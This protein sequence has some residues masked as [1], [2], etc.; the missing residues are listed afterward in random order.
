MRAIQVA[1]IGQAVV[2]IAFYAA[3]VSR[4]AHAASRDRTRQ[5]EERTREMR[6]QAAR[7]IAAR[8]LAEQASRAKSQFLATMSHELRTPLNAVIG[9]AEILQHEI[10]G[11][12]GHPRYMEDVKIIV[13]SGHSLLDLVNDILDISRIASDRFDVTIEPLCPAEILR[14]IAVSFRPKLSERRQSLTLEQ[15]DEGPPVQADRRRL[16]QCLRNLINNASRY[17]GKGA[18][19]ELRCAL[20]G[21]RL[22]IEILDD[23]PGIPEQELGNIK[24]PFYRRSDAHTT[25]KDGLGLGLFIVSHLMSAMGGALT[26]ENR[27]EGGLCARLSLPVTRGHGESDQPASEP[28]REPIVEKPAAA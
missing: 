2:M 7:A 8:E 21:E 24:T 5:L 12:L 15:P 28:T 17:A 14:E 1:L 6:D 19:I 27:P 18:A 11:P 23:G 3:R 16:K 22:T 26:L 13:S 20:D 4:A 9:F 25:N 10:Y